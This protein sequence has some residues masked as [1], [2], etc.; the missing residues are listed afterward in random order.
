[1]LFVYALLRWCGWEKGTIPFDI[2]PLFESMEG[3]KNAEQIMRELFDNPEY[4]QHIKN[5][6]NRQTIMLGFSDGTKDGGYLQAN[7]SI[8]KTKEKLT[9]VCDEYNIEAVFFD[10]RGGPPARGGGKTHRFYAAQG[11]NIANHAIQLTIQGQTITSKYGTK[12]HFMHNCEQLVTAGLS[13]R[14]FAGENIIS[15]KSRELIEELA[16]I[17]YEKY[18]G[19]KNHKM[20][21]PYLENKSTLKYYGRTN[22]GSRPVKRG[23][24]KKLD[25]QD[26]RAI[27]FVGSWSQLKQN[28]PGYFGLGTAIKTLIDKGRLNDLKKLFKDAEYFKVMILNS[29]MSLLKCNFELTSY[30][31]KDKEYKEF[32]NILYDEYKLSKEMTLLISGYSTLMEEDPVTR[33][34]VQ[35]REQL[36]LPLL[37]IQQYALQKREQN[38]ANAEVYE[39]IVQRSLYGNINASR[40]SA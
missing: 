39:K 28:V 38:T 33:D 30:I 12:E 8:F 5:R 17:S 10:G 3:M 22:I 36:V 16:Q 20:F 11:P 1:M 9:A 18:N 21:V 6:G 31:S 19:L 34:S 2:I 37:V 14:M 26:L 4:R 15:E 29:M 25:L 40:N 35:I 32:W 27:P 13:N 7:W 23:S 24:D